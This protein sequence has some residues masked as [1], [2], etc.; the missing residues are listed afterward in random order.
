MQSFCK[1]VSRSLERGSLGVRSMQSAAHRGGPHR[2]GPHRGG[3]SGR[4]KPASSKALAE[5]P[6]LGIIRLDY[7][8]PANKG[9][10]DSSESFNFDVYYKVVPGFTFEMCQKGVMTPEVEER[11]K[12]SINWLI[13]EK[14]V[15]AITGDCGFMMWFQKLARQ[16]TN[17][18]I[19]MSSLCILPAVTCAFAHNEE[20]MI[21]TA[22]GDALEPMR[23]LIR[24]EC[25]VDTEEERYH[26][27]GC[28]DVDGFEAVADGGKVDYDK[29]EPGIIKLAQQSVE[30]YPNSRAI[31][32]E[33]TELPQFADSIRN[34][35]GL[36]VYDAINAS[37]FFIE[38]FKD[39]VR[40]GLNDW[41]KDWDGVQ[42]EYTYGDN[43]TDE[44]KVDEDAKMPHQR[45]VA[46]TESPI[47]E[48]LVDSEDIKKK[49]MKIALFGGTFDPPHKGHEA[50]A[51]A[52]IEMK[53]IDIDEVWLIP[54]Q[55]NPDK[56]SN[57]VK[58][59]H[60]VKMLDIIFKDDDRI[61]VNDWELQREG[62]SYTYHTLKHFTT[63]YPEH[64][65]YFVMGSDQRF[66]EWDHA[67]ESAA[68]VDFIL[69]NR[70]GHIANP[71]DVF[72]GVKN[73]RYTI[74]EF[75]DES[76]S[77]AVRTAIEAGEFT[78]SLSREVLMYIFE[79]GLYVKNDDTLLN[80]KKNL[81]L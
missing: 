5:A 49:G 44:E 75:H 80:L 72:R 9:D 21:M 18:P 48:R 42:E 11:F 79:N 38:G 76:N 46:S 59:V 17:I 66:G 41:Q 43:L 51:R 58:G 28:Q 64:K 77:T 78:E 10:I 13:Y 56:V 39:N 65:F 52:V 1:V 60:R 71:S 74:V 23:D 6:S 40:F 70:A 30:M 7:D 29:T 55:L 50:I 14:K 3:H 61:K 54:A 33:C 24:E 26:I 4:E 12:Y 31:V 81:G 45:E 57:P 69:V 36:P 62:K 25:G 68:M 37:S 63:T 47:I 20:I 35:T 53:K 73:A 19:F 67:E 32:L 8:Y 2:G 22:N 15:K 27:I 16:S 34:A